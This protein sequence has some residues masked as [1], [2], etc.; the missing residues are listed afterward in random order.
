MVVIAT[1]GI[2]FTLKPVGF[3]INVVSA[4]KIESGGTMYPLVLNR[5]GRELFITSLL[6]SLLQEKRMVLRTIIIEV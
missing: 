4:G 6:P 2:F 1:A 5:E 3:L